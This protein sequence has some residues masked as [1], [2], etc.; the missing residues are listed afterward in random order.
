MRLEHK[1]VDARHIL[2]DTTCFLFKTENQLPKKLTSL[3]EV[4]Q[5][6][7]IPHFDLLCLDLFL[8]YLQGAD[9]NHLEQQQGVVFR[10]LHVLQEDLVPELVSTLQLQDHQI[11]DSQSVK[12]EQIP[13]WSLV[14]STYLQQ[15]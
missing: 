12:L 5:K 11:K 6:E 10:L 7:S 8:L 13:L 1:Q 15:V 4:R 2:K 3:R 9:V 14:F